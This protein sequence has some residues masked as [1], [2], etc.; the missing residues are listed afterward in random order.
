M[1]RSYA[2]Y[3]RGILTIV[4]IM[5]SGFA[6]LTLS[7]CTKQVESAQAEESF[8]AIKAL[9]AKKGD[10]SREYRYSGRIKPVQV[11]NVSSKAVGE[12][13]QVFFD[14]G[15]RVG[16]GDILFVLDSVVAQN[17]VKSLENQL[18][19]QINQVESA[20][21]STKTQ[22]E[23]AKNNYTD[24]TALYNNGAISQQQLD[25][26]K[27]AY[28]QAEIAY[29]GA[30]KS[31]DLLVNAESK[32]SLVAQIDI[33]KE[34]LAYL[35]VTS[36]IDGIVASR[37]I[38]QGEI[39]SSMPVFKIVD[40]DTVTLDIGIPE[41]KINMIELNQ[42]VDVNV[43]SIGDKL[44]QGRITSIAP[45]ADDSTLT[46]SVK[47]EIDNGQGLIKSGMYAEAIVVGERKDSV[48]L[49]PRNSMQLDGKETYVYVVEDGKA[50]RVYIKTGLDNGEEIEVTKGITEGASI[51]IQGQS[52]V[53][54]G[55]KV[56]VV[57]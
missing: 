5:I 1:I 11:V 45:A 40:L 57:E 6:A 37:N 29:D 53:A 31:Y 9:T 48:L 24:M 38:E 39:V 49:I 44:F 17:N 51:I 36:P 54:D 8:V 22:Y 50:K 52:Y 4:L 55:A 43:K 35:T 21:E 15:D 33:A 16:K 56:L 12:V 47:V 46:Y 2:T 20:L 18:D 19:T 25:A 34:S 26:S 14:V 42:S 32:S 28:D 27:L 41:N 10:I 7:G 13:N 3:K 23:S 30:K